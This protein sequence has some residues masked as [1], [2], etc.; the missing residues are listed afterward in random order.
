MGVSNQPAWRPHDGCK[1][2][3]SAPHYRVFDGGGG[4]GGGKG[5]APAGQVGEGWGGGYWET[6]QILLKTF[7]GQPGWG[8]ASVRADSKRDL[9]SGSSRST[10]ASL[11]AGL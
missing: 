1:V 11:G 7:Q 2:V 3:T 6:A 9:H 8:S 5:G 4:G 10:L